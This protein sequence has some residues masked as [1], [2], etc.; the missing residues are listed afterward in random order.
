MAQEVSIQR[1]GEIAL[2]MPKSLGP[3]QM[4]IYHIHVASV[5][6]YIHKSYSQVSTHVEFV[7]TTRSLIETQ[8]IC[9]APSTGSWQTEQA[10]RTMLKTLRWLW[11]RE[12][13]FPK[14]S[15]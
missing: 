12:P 15:V 4:G 2:Y 11:E 5:G 1:Q 8:H 3:Y 9:V 10:K 7:T 14:A 13:M 6:K